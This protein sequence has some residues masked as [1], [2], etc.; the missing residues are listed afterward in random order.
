[1]NLSTASTSWMAHET[2]DADRRARIAWAASV[3]VALDSLR[4]EIRST[5]EAFVRSVAKHLRSSVVDGRP[6]VVYSAVIPTSKWA[7]APE[8][9]LYSDRRL[10]LR[11]LSMETLERALFEEFRA[12]ALRC[13]TDR[14]YLRMPVIWGRGVG[15]LLPPRAANQAAQIERA[16]AIAGIEM[17]SSPALVLDLRSGKPVHHFP[18]SGRERWRAYIDSVDVLATPVGISGRFPSKEQVLFELSQQ[19]LNLPYVGKEGLRALRAL[20]ERTDLIEWDETR[21]AAALGPLLRGP[22][23]SGERL[24][25]REK[26]KAPKVRPVPSS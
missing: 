6:D 3:T 23:P 20:V 24:R 19:T 9:C 11:T 5:S 14:V 15:V 7:E 13:A 17:I 26:L 2:L 16:A 8:F 1:M 18:S 4:Y 22:R 12:N 25:R 21:P 10:V